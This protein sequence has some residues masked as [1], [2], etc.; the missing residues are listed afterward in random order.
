MN[1]VALARFDAARQALAKAKTID[2][3]K[4]IRDKAEALRQYAKQAGESLE[5][6]NDIAE[7]KLRAERRAGELL[8][9]MEK[10]EG[11]R[12]VMPNRDPS[13]GYIMQ[14]PG[15]FSMK[16]PGVTINKVSTLS[17][18]GINKLQSHRWQLASKIP[19]ERFERHIIE[20]KAANQELTSS[21]ML[22]LAQEILRQERRDAFFEADPIAGKYRIWYADPPWRYADSG[23]ITGTDSYGRAERHYPTMSIEELCML[24]Q[25][26]QEAC[27]DNAVL[28]LWTTSP[29]LEDG[30]RVINAW[31]FKYK[32]SFVWDKIAHNFGH[33]NSVRHELLLVCVRGSC[34]P[35]VD[36]K[37][38][39]VIS[40]ERSNRHSEKPKQFRNIIDTLYPTGNRIELFARSGADGW[41]I[42]GNEVANDIVSSQTA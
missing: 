38:D 3:V 8:G 4:D 36:L 32:T 11:N 24:G 22:R 16:P 42:W 5:M 17:D 6:Q 12:G 1:N 35:D 15:G 40:I 28:F 39:S 27:E 19:E 7:I 30:F 34:T 26:I 10:A 14:N 13:S 31:G 37:F 9:E 21:G 23:V 29:M 25:D 18:L 20:T 41:D 33:Y 2:E